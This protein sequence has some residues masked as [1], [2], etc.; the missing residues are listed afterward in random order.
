MPPAKW[1]VCKVQ[2]C[3]LLAIVGFSRAHYLPVMRNRASAG[4]IGLTPHWHGNSV[5]VQNSKLYNRRYFALLVSIL[6]LTVLAPIVEHGFWAR[7]LIGSLMF[8]AL[9]TGSLAVSLKGNVSAGNIALATLASFLW[10]VGFFAE[11]LPVD[12]VYL[13]YVTYTVLL[14][15]F[16][17]VGR[18]MLEDILQ[19]EVTFDRI[20]GGVCVFVLLGLC[21]A[22]LHMMVAAGDPHSYR[23][24]FDLS[25]NLGN[26]LS[27]EYRYPIFVYFSFCTLSTVG[28]GDIVPV[29]RLA[30][31]CAMM[32][33]V[34]GQ[35]Y[36]AI[37]VARLVG[38]HIAS[39]AS[40][41]R[42]TV[43]KVRD[44]SVET[45]EKRKELEETLRR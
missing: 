15:F 11:S 3:A 21:F 10:A 9:W 42:L 5:P 35:L 34:A 17:N 30:R 12:A 14:F 38:L 32:E 20:C 31:S 41:A 16:G 18:L 1:L 7:M 6:A 39:H 33:S 23:D 26:S 22:L 19:G 24:N 36:L 37:L 43:G 2:D 40:Q 44:E 25:S 45:D 28:Y 27:H 13:H 29:S 4:I 8:V